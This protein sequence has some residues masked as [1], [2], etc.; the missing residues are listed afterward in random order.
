MIDRNT[1]DDIARVPHLLLACDFDGTL[2]PIVNDPDDATVL[3]EALAALH[4]LARIPRTTVAIVSGRLRQELVDRFGDEDFIL[5]GEH[6]ADSGGGAP[7]EPD[8]LARTRQAVDKVHR[9][10][11]GS[12]IEHKTMSVVFHYRQVET[13][14]AS[15]LA[16]LRRVA[17]DMPD[18]EVMEGKAVLEISVPHDD[19]GDVI[20]ALRERVG[21]D[22]ILF[23]GDD[24]TDETVF[25]RLGL[26]DLGVKVGPEE[27]A[28]TARV[29]DPEE[30]AEFL[31]LLA[32]RREDLT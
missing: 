12:R 13:D 22:A 9:E 32:E 4:R 1:I 31:A 7:P 2:A 29:S 16:E 8:S 17:D 21:A 3:P 14:P 5:V 19:K 26:P 23:L 11:P 18:L 30:V 28:A 20:V 25:P 6:G 15:A 24:V 27:T 10:T